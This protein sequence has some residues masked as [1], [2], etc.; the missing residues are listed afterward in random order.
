MSH[1]HPVPNH[2]LL[3]RREWSPLHL[4]ST[5]GQPDGDQWTEILVQ[6]YNVLYIRTLYIYMYITPAHTLLNLD[7][8]MRAQHTYG[9][10][11]M[12]QD[13][14]E[15]MGSLQQSDRKPTN[16]RIPWHGWWGGNTYHRMVRFEDSFQGD[17]NWN[18]G[19]WY[20]QCVCGV[21]PLT[22]KI[23]EWG[24]PYMVNALSQ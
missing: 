22:V 17:L 12:V 7:I 24:C 8:F 5:R 13:C 2:L 1:Y 9:Y 18:A 23:H 14:L 11:D 3:A 20:A 4:L 10:M 21:V 16:Y 6:I 15:I 19:D